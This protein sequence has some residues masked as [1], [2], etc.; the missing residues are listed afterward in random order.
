VL[1]TRPQLRRM[2]VW[3]L[4]AR[5]RPINCGSVIWSGPKMFPSTSAAQWWVIRLRCRLWMR[6]AGCPC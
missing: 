1:P 3:L 4:P 5:Y 6:A 2:I